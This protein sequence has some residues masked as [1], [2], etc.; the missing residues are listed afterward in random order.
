M[1]IEF[2]EKNEFFESNSKF[3]AE[4]EVAIYD[5]NS[6]FPFDWNS[7][8]ILRKILGDKRILLPPPNKFIGGDFDASTERIPFVRPSQLL[9]EIRMEE[10]FCIDISL[11]LLRSDDETLW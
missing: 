8:G 1:F 4:H 2:S 10:T 7:W 9:I 3:L 5:N 6:F 11:R